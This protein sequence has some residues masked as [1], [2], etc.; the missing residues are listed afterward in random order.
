M[1]RSS[2]CGVLVL[3]ALATIG[4]GCCRHSDQSEIVAEGAIFSVEY[5]LENGKTG[6]FTR[7]NMAEAVPGGNGSWNIDAH[8]RLTRDYLIITRPQQKDL[9]PQ[10]IPASRLVNVQFG[11]G[12]IRAV[13]ENQPAPAKPR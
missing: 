3:F 4:S 7:L 6:G 5:K 1:I 10:V 9:G 11:D 12:G 2:I 13:N 8:G